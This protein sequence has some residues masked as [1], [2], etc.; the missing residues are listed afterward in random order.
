MVVV[1]LVCVLCGRCQ[2]RALVMVVVV[3][4]CVLCMQCVATSICLCVIVTH[5]LLEDMSLKYDLE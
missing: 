1:V 5:F 4:V 3:L 2:A